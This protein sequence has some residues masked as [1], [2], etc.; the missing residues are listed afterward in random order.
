MNQLEGIVSHENANEVLFEMFREK[1]EEV[2]SIGKFLAALEK[3]GLKRTDQRLKELF[4]NLWTV[5][6]SKA[7]AANRTTVNAVET[8]RVDKAT[9]TRLMHDNIVLISKAF[10]QQ[11]IIPEFQT[12]CAQI[13]EVWA[14]CKEVKGGKVA[15]YIPQLARVDPHYWGMRF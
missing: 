2:V 11:L 6:Q 1:D 15:S 9:F 10:R 14:K 12:F 8:L 4:D 5:Q 3:T 7:A 13:Y